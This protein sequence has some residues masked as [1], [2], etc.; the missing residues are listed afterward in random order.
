MA[1]LLGAGT[2][3]G[4]GTLGCLQHWRHQPVQQHSG[5]VTERRCGQVRAR[6]GPGATRA[7]ADWVVMPARPLLVR[8][9][10]C[11]LSLTTGSLY[12][13]R[14]LAGSRRAPWHIT[15]WSATPMPVTDTSACCT[16]STLQAAPGTGDVSTCAA[17]CMLDRPSVAGPHM[18]RWCFCPCQ[19]SP[20]QSAPCRLYAGMRP[21]QSMF[22]YM[23]CTHNQLHR[24]PCLPVFCVCCLCGTISRGSKQTRFGPASKPWPT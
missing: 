12:A 10:P 11:V 18:A 6:M 22:R 4:T 19:V 21:A 9:W 23:L 1:L 20:N 2:A 15:T 7:T 16:A 24:L 13:A 17:A 14:G 5:A 3:C 8:V